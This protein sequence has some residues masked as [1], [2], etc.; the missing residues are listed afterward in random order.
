M[1]SWNDVKK[2][3]G[4]MLDITKIFTYHPAHDQD[5]VDAHDAV[6]DKVRSVALWMDQNVPD[7]PEKTLAIRHLQYAMM[8]ANS[9]IAQNY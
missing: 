3:A 5:T 7:C 1:I 4:L 8:M 9:A 6:R 2:K